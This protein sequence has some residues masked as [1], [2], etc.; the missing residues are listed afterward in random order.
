MLRHASLLSGSLRLTLLLGMAS[1]IAL[2]SYASANSIASHHF[3]RALERQLVGTWEG[4]DASGK[5]SKLVFN[6]DHSLWFVRNGI[7]YDGDKSGMQVT[8]EID[9]S[10]QPIHL[11]IIFNDGQT[12]Q[13]Y[14]SIMRFENDDEITLRSGSQRPESFLEHKDGSQTSLFRR[15]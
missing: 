11:D 13:R 6:Q 8:W 15:Y 10:Q 14:L 9:S 3:A 1:A 4:L 12:E 7:T 2:T 5:A